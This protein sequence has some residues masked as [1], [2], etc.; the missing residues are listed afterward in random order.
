[1]KESQNNS[2]QILTIPNLLSLFRFVLIPIFI[3]FYLHQKYTCALIVLL[4]S[5]LSDVMDGYIARNTNTVT[6]L[7]KVLDPIA[8]KL[9][10]AAIMICLSFEFKWMLVLFIVLAVKEITMMIFGILVLKITGKVNGAKWYGKL[11]TTIT[12][13]IMAIHIVFPYI[14]DSLSMWLC[15]V[16]MLMM[17]HSLIRYIAFDFGEIASYNRNK[18]QESD[19]I[20]QPENA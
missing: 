19:V 16:N 6:D 7:G 2:E 15:L 18:V 17:I 10:Q 20:E 5:T 11:C 3:F 8:D 4:L 12:V 14:S 1:M 9:T 13:V